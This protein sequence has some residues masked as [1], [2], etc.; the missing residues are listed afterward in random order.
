ML[1]IFIGFDFSSTASLG[2]FSKPQHTQIASMNRVDVIAKGIEGQIQETIGKIT[3][4]PQ[5]QMIGKAKQIEGQMINSANDLRDNLDFQAESKRIDKEI[6][7]KIQD[8]VH[9]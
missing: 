7:N 2:A 5:D 4:N 9:K 3:D 6:E 8:L 1:T